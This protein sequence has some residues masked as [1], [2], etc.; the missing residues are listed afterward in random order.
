MTRPRS[1][2]VRHGGAFLAG[3][4]CGPLWR[5]LRRWLE[6]RE[7]RDGTRATPDP[8]LAE[9][10]DALRQGAVDY[11]A[12]SANGRSYGHPAP[13]EPLS[14]TQ[15]VTTQE[16]AMLLHVGERQARRLAARAGVIAVARNAWR[17]VD[18]LALAQSRREA[19]EE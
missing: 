7:V 11:S 1:F 9:A 10:L 19:R 12:M 14:E 3:E 6:S 18:V 17:R 2:A 4:L 13:L 15:L 8:V 16:M 5:E